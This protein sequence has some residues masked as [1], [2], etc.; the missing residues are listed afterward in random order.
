MPRKKKYDDGIEELIEKIKQELSEFE[1]GEKDLDVVFDPL[2]QEC[3]ELAKDENEV[4]Q[5]LKEAAN[6]LIG[7]LKKIK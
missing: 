4:K 2:V 3:V 1:L 7:V 6:T 5:C